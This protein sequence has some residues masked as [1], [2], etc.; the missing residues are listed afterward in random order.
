MP[1]QPHS[2]RTLF[3]LNALNRRGIRGRQAKLCLRK[4]SHEH[5]ALQ[6]DYYDHEVIDRARLPSW[7]ATPWLAHRIR[8]DIPGPAGFMRTNQSLSEVLTSIPYRLG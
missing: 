1:V 3:L 6:I 8:R 5:I 4:Y 2:A 7:A